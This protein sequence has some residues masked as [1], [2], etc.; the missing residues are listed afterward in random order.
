M[1]DTKA[2]HG[3]VPASGGPVDPSVLHDLVA[4]NHI[5]AHQGVLGGYGHCSVRHP[6][7]PDRYFPARSLSPAVITVDDIVSAFLGERVP[8][9]EIRDGFGMT[10]PLMRDNEHG[11]TPAKTMALGD[12]IVFMDP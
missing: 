12:D 4:A 2:A 7:A 8:D 10:D 6:N 11:R 3:R 9:F 1:N 5:C